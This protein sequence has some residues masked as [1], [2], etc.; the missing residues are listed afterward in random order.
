ME[1]KDKILLGSNTAK[2]GFQ[3]EKD[4]CEKFNNW[5]KDLE[6]QKWLVFMQYELDKIEYVKAVV[7]HGEKAD[8]NVQVMLKLKDAVDTENIQVKLVSNKSG[9]NQIDKRWLSH[10]KDLW[11]MDE[12]V[13]RLLQFFT[14]EKAPYK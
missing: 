12:E 2:N 4:I 11:K 5:Q 6:A 1:T 3:N 10:Y 8:V 9:F 13:F 7:I 14:G